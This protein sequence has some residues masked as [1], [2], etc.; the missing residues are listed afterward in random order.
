[1]RREGYK[2]DQGAILT[3]LGWAS[4]WQNHTLSGEYRPEAHA[5]I[6]GLH[7]NSASF[8]AATKLMSNDNRPP[9]RRKIAH[10]KETP[11]TFR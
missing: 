6:L 5:L 2:I 9:E 3:D 1:M 7:T 4:T 11:C 10:T 8:P